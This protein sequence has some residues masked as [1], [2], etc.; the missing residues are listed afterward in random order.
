[1]D[2]TSASPQD[3][4]KALLNL[5]TI[6]I[7]TSL[8]RV[9]DGGGSNTALQLSSSL[10]R[11]DTLEVGSINALST[12]P[13]VIVSFDSNKFKSTPTTTFAF[14]TP[15][16]TITATYSMTIG[17]RMVIAAA[18]ANMTLTLPASAS[19][20]PYEFIIIKSVASH[21]V[22]IN[23]TSGNINGGA[24]TNLTSQWQCVRLRTDGTNWY[25]V[26]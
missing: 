7:G 25:I 9:Q 17:D 4:F 23:T 6:D 11:V 12:I 1:M 19:S 21:T 14:P 26:N 24:S 20:V 13:T 5:E 22:T 15:P 8:K 18:A 3:Y 10:A 2:L 16:V